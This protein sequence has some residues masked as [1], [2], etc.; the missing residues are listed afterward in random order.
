M[1]KIL[2]LNLFAEETLDIKLP[3]IGPKP[4]EVL[5]LSKPTREMTIKMMDFRNLRQNA[6][7]EVIIERMDS[8]VHLI[9]N[10]NTASTE[11]SVDY[12]SNSLSTPMKQAIITAY[13]TWIVGIE[14]SPN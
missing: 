8:M 2:D 10:S 9:L 3:A 7:S 13:A 6:K 5:H 12:V 4:G 11:I 1:S 14:Q